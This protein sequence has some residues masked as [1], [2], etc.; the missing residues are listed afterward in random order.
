LA[1]NVT[2]VFLDLVPVL[3][4]A[5]DHYGKNIR[6]VEHP[7]NPGQVVAFPS[8]WILLTGKSEFFAHPSL[9]SLQT[10]AAPVNF[11]PWR[12]DYSSLLSVLKKNP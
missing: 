5:A 9:N 8:R 6:L 11:V 7:G 2:N 4:V 1:L 10:V 3:K 12:D